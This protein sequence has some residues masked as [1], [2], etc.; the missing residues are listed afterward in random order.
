M[1]LLNALFGV[2][3]VMS[4][5]NGFA[6]GPPP[7]PRDVIRAIG[8]ATVSA[9]PDQAIITVSVMT[10]APTAQ[11][12]AADNATKTSAVLAAVKKAL[13][14]GAEVKTVGYS[15]APAYTY[16]REGGEPKITGYQASNSVLVKTADLSRVGPVIDAATAA[17]ANNIQGLQFTI[18]D[19]RA[20]ERQA[21][22]MAARNA[23][24]KTKAIA[25][26]LGVTVGRVVMAEEGGASVQPVYRDTMAFKAAAASPTPIES[27]SVEVHATV[28]VT[29]AIA[30]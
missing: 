11:A 29:V 16:P 23:V 26:G 21:L 20:V 8:E 17:G 13:E 25:A 24:E 15:L 5:I 22:E 14:P 30:P 6:Q 7:P 1:R 10:Q 3:L 19:N 18:K 12:A 4:P 2:L 9:A 27:G 28:T